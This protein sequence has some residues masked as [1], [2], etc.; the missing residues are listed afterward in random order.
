MTS[1]GDTVLLLR[2]R[3]DRA[4]PCRL[5]GVLLFAMTTPG[6]QSP[7][8]RAPLV[9]LIGGFEVARKQPAP[10]AFE[11]APVAIGDD[12]KRSIVATGLSRLTFHVTVPAGATFDVAA[13]VHPRAWDSAGAATLFMVGVSDG[14]WY[15]T[16]RSFVVDPARSRDRRWHPV[17]IDLE[18][19]AGLTV[20]IILNTR[21]AGAG[22]T[23]V[24][25]WGA[26]AVNLR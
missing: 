21:P 19:F 3:S 17:A 11:V 18:E 1:P 25:V 10:A 14:H 20:D 23:P 12:V 16:K 4:L 9:D 8:G 15:Q 2:T 26:P 24:G 6:C 13:A 5:L 22:G 7:S